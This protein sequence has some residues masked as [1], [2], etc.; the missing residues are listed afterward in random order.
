MIEN[1]VVVVDAE[2]AP[3]EPEGGI[4]VPLEL[5]GVAVSKEPA[6]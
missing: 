3:L 5:V 2:A 6:G 1:E 4:V